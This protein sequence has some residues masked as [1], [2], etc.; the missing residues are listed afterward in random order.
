MF[1]I[2]K[3]I[4]FLAIPPG[5]FILGVIL[6][7][8]LY[9]LKLKKFF[10]GILI[11]LGLEI[12][13]ISISPVSSFLL[14]PL[15]D[16][17]DPVLAE[18]LVEKDYDAI[19][20][21]GGGQYKYAP[22]YDRSDSSVSG[23]LREDAMKRAVYGQYVYKTN[24]V[25]IIVSGGFVYSK[26]GDTNSEAE[27]MKRTLVDLGV[28]FQDIYLEE[29]SRDTFE[30]LKYSKEI[31]EDHGWDRIL[32]VTSAY[33]MTRAKNAAET[34]EVEVIPAPTDFKTKRGDFNAWN[35]LPTGSDLANSSKALREYLGLVYYKLR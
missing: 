13:L 27:I 12:Y 10:Y 16:A 8:I 11:V 2:S 30:N 26:N 22:E 4:S 20:I 25:P 32:L 31:M 7:Y 33:H 1:I 28:E 3:L 17:S 35:F 15:E 5:S 24:P 9:R 23:T 19:L 14:K 29:Q 6:L 34:H 18:K 21:L